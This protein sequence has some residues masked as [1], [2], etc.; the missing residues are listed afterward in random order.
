MQVF[1]GQQRLRRQLQSGEHRIRL[2]QAVGL[3]PVEQA[4]RREKHIKFRLRMGLQPAADDLQIRRCAVQIRIPGQCL[5]RDLRPVVIIQ[6][7]HVVPPDILVPG[8]KLINGR[9]AALPQGQQSID[10]IIERIPV[11]EIPHIV[12][13]V[14]IV[15]ILRQRAG[16]TALIPHQ[17]VGVQAEDHPL[18]RV[19]CKHVNKSI[20]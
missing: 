16:Q 12:Q 2:P 15:K 17:D 1:V 10:A 5:V 9:A 6:G 11:E 4:V 19:G 18:R 20:G 7:G 14:G 13:R 3:V 8:K